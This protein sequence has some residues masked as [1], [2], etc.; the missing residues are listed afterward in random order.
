MRFA[1]IYNAAR[2]KECART[3]AAAVGAGQR[4]ASV[5]AC[6]LARPDGVHGTG[7]VALASL[8]GAVMGDHDRI[9]RGAIESAL[10]PVK[11]ATA[12]SFT[13]RAKFAGIDK[14]E[15]E[16]GIAVPAFPSV[17]YA[18]RPDVTGAL[19][20]PMMRVRAALRSPPSGAA[21]GPIAPDAMAARTEQARGLACREISHAVASFR[22]ARNSAQKDA[23]KSKIRAI[24]HVWGE[25]HSVR[26]AATVA[27][28]TL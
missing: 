26:D 13:K 2:E 12:A 5:L 23:A 27:G 28:W 25:D 8:A 16:D 22:S 14:E 20:R 10:G 17:R 11:P 19:V 18:D 3:V 7:G 6:E 1:H 9:V 21:P 24:L 4:A 15:A